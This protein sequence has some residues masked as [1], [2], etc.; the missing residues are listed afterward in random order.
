MKGL[1]VRTADETARTPA[2]N[3]ARADWRSFAKGLVPFGRRYQAENG[4]GPTVAE[5]LAQSGLVSPTAGGWQMEAWQRVMEPHLR[6]V[7]WTASA[8]DGRGP[9]RWRPPDSAQVEQ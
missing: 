1:S 9:V 3:A 6:A 2:R 8:G 4:I 5:I 7:G